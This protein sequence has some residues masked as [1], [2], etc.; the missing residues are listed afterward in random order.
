MTETSS[1]PR[2]LVITRTIDAPRALVF[3]AFTDAKHLAQWWGPEGFTTPDASADV[4]PGGALRLDMHGPDGTVYLAGGT[5]HEITPPER[6]VFST[7]IL[8]ETDEKLADILNT[9]TLIERNGKTE[10]TLNVRCVYAS[11]LVAH[12]LDG[13]EEGWLS[14]LV[15]LE[16]YLKSR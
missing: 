1:H 2:D 16:D 15:C 10:L 7:T 12:H 9:L 3:A 5:F 14:S 11:P 13:M 6:L 8:S 4:R